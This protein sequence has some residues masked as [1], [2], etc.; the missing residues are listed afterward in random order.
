MISLTKK[1]VASLIKDA[2]FEPVD[3]GT[4]AESRP[5]DPPSPIWNK[6]L[7]ANE[8]RERVVQFRESARARDTH[9]SN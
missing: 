4:L 6:V 9:L 2:G 3:I 5:I 7:T 8:V 1:V